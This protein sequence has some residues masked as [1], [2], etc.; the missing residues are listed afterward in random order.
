MY[1]YNLE[2]LYARNSSASQ[3]IDSQLELG[4]QYFSNIN[5]K[6][7]LTITDED[8]SAIKIPMMERTGL[9][10]VLELVKQ[11]KVKKLVVYKRDRLARDFYQYCEIAEI[12]IEY[13]VEVIFTASNEPAFTNYIFTEGIFGML[14]QLEGGNIVTRSADALNHYPR[15]LLGYKIPER[16]VFIIDHEIAEKI[17]STFEEFVQ[18]TNEEEFFS[19]LSMKREWIGKNGP[20]KVLK[21]LIN[22]LYAGLFETEYGFYPHTHCPPI[23]EP[24]LY[25][26]ARGIMKNFYVKY[27]EVLQEVEKAKVIIPRCGVCDREMTLRRRS[28]TD[29]GYF[30]CSKKHK[31]VSVEVNELNDELISLISNKIKSFSCDKYKTTFFKVVKLREKELVLERRELNTKYKVIRKPLLTTNITKMCQKEIKRILSDLKEVELELKRIDDYQVDL[32]KAKENMNTFI[33][34]AKHSIERNATEKLKLKLVQMM[35]ES[36]KVYDNHMTAFLFFADV[37]KESEPSGR[38]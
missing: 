2:I 9:A 17:Q 30:T 8:V 22:P 7:Y 20:N 14:G 32:L 29:T 26:Q 18:L 13:K 15:S 6:N 35:V 27:L 10:Q 12:L 34:L 37:I 24:E 36:I 25:H 5:Q 21:L 3:T 1:S 4:E 23:I 11:K 16:K 38:T 33:Q 28:I 31:K 19:F